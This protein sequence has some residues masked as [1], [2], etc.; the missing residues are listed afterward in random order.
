MKTDSALTTSCVMHMVRE[1]GDTGKGVA[2]HRSILS[3]MFT[4]YDL[5]D[6]GY[7]EAGALSK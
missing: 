3:L 7:P 6:T 5:K 4:H 1:S 2:E